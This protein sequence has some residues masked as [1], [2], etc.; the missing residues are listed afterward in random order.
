[1]E[2]WDASLQ[3][4]FDL[5]CGRINSV[6]SY[7]KWEKESLKD[8]DHPL[9]PYN[10]TETSEIVYFPEGESE[11]SLEGRLIGGCIDCLVT[12]LGTRF[13][14]VK[15]FDE[16]YAGDGLLWFLESCDLTPMGIRRAIWQ[17]KEAG[18]FSH[19]KGFLIGRP[20]C[21]GE[22]MLGL[23][24]YHAVTDLLAEYEVPIILDLDIGHLPP[25]M[26]L[27]CGAKARVHAKG[28]SFTL[29]YDWR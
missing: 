4:A 12:L 1:M 7:G 14:R 27:V 11:V 3:D 21:F 15:E 17:M 9:V 24:H 29:E 23:D 8:A 18:W 13:D 16:R 19:V 28:N 20:L 25:M 5:L 26:P 2:P 10:L 6:H 22:S